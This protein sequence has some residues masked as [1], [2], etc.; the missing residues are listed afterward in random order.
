MLKTLKPGRRY[1]LI[2][3][4]EPYAEEIYEVLKRGQ[5][6]K[7]E[8]PEGDISFREWVIHDWGDAFP[9]ATKGGDSD[10]A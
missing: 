8:W 1:F 4:D 6:A 9:L 3:L 2:N 7:G 5:Q 10:P